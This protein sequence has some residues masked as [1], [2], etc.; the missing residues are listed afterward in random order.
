MKRVSITDHVLVIKKLLK[1]NSNLNF[2]LIE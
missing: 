2:F 1:F